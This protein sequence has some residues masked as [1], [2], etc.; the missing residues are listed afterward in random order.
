M[1]KEIAILLSIAW[2]IKVE[3]LCTQQLLLYLI[4]GQFYKVPALKRDIDS[5]ALNVYNVIYRNAQQSRFVIADTERCNIDG[6]VGTAVS[7]G[8]HNC[9]VN[10]MVSQGKVWTGK[11]AISITVQT[12]NMDWLQQTRQWHSRPATNLRCPRSFRRKPRIKFGRSS[13]LMNLY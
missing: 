9:Q 2:Y 3:L 11:D 13:F 10:T 4:I 7:Y 8:A 1:H 5:Q 12:K 6:S